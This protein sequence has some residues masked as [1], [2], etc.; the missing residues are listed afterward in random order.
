MKTLLLV[1][2]VMASVA[3]QAEPAADV[4]RSTQESEGGARSVPQPST[5]P[6]GPTTTTTEAP[7]EPSTTTTVAP[8]PEPTTTVAPVVV[9]RTTTTVEYEPPSPQSRTTGRGSEPPASDT[10]PDYIKQCES[11]GSYTAVNPNGHYGAWQFSQSTWNSVG[12]TGRP[13]HATPA[14]QDYRASLLW[15]GGRGAS[16]WACA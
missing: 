4:G 8:E 6:S 3:C 10:P 12:G 14:E 7:P 13:D 15:D 16:H 1:G 9:R 5:P 11:G 2:A